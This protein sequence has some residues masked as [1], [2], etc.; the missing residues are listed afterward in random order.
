M[1]VFFDISAALDTQ[2]N[3]MVGL[4]AVAWPNRKY[5]PVQGT[6]YIRPTLIQGSTV[7]A[8][9]GLGSDLSTGIY[10]VDIFS[11]SDE[12]KNEAV[13][14]ADTIADHFARDTDLTYNSRTVT[15]KSTSQTRQFV[16][17]GWYHL[18]LDI[19]YCAY[20]VKR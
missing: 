19:V 20:T 14:M 3:T 13:T 16:E 9:I 2:L 10:Q 7:T 8:T 18:V 12:G 6:L 5:I 17:D 15:I 1:S 11:P 4:P